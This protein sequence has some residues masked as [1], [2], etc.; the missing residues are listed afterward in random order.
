VVADPSERPAD[1]HVVYA[2]AHDA[3][4]EGDCWPSSPAER[5]GAFIG[6]LLGSHNCPLLV[7]VLGRLVEAWPVLVEDGRGNVFDYPDV[8]VWV[9]RNGN[10][11]WKDIYGGGMLKMPILETYDCPDI[12][13]GHD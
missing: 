1:R 12:D 10:A 7:K 11:D 6:V 2:H 5:F 8:A 13:P 3:L 9:R 4:E